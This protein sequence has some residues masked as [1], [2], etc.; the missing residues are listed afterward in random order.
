MRIQNTT[1]CD[2]ITELGRGLRTTETHAT[3]GKISVLPPCD[4]EQ[5]FLKNILIEKS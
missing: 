2:M 3:E 4:W 5:W 1:Q